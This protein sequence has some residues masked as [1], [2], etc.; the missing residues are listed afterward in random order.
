MT[1]KRD[2]LLKFEQNIPAELKAIK[3][4]FEAEVERSLIETWDNRKRIIMDIR[5]INKWIPSNWSQMNDDQLYEHFKIRFC[6]IERFINSNPDGEDVGEFEQLLTSDIFGIGP[7]TESFAEDFNEMTRKGLR[8][9]MAIEFCSIWMRA[10]M[11]EIFQ[12]DY[13]MLAITNFAKMEN[14]LDFRN[15]A[16]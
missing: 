9:D 7:I 3:K 10:F 15:G 8:K 11:K 16:L 4:E 13:Y 14:T 5:L 2:Y 6:T 1:C 12:V